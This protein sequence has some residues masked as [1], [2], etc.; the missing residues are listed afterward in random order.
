MGKKV[1]LTADSTCDLSPAL[2]ERFQVTT[3]P[4]H[5]ILNGKEYLDGVDLQPDDILNAYAREKSLPKTAA[6]NASEYQ[7]FF[8]P[9]LDDGCEVVHV[10][11]AGALS[12]SHGSCQSAAK[13]LGNVYPVDSCSLSTG[14]GQLLLHARDLIDRGLPA[15][16]VAEALAKMTKRIQASF[17]I[18]SLEFLYKGGRCSA[19]AMLGANMLRLKPCIEVHNSDG[20]MGVG[21]KYRGAF[22]SVLLKYCQ[23][24]LGQAEVDGRYA[25]ITHAGVAPELLESIKEHV[26]SYNLFKEV[27]ITRA[28]CT[29]TAHCGRNTLGV[30]F[31]N[32]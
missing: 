22:E 7:E 20:S 27:F 25:F 8:K 12:L 6:I 10:N 26:L 15:K 4:L 19:L 2:K 29:I 17:V 16:E 13:E 28:G 9:F 11:I 5:V 21:K 14:S 23:D 30:L 1:I 3:M 18:D 31:L 24:K 32:K